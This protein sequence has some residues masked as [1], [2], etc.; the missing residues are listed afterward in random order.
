MQIYKL[1]CRN[2]STSRWCHP[3]DLALR[4]LIS[5]FF[6]SFCLPPSN[7]KM[8]C[9]NYDLVPRMRRPYWNLSTKGWAGWRL[10]TSAM[11]LRC[12]SVWMLVN[13]KW[14]PDLHVARDAGL[15]ESTK[16]LWWKH[17]G[18]LNSCNNFLTSPVSSVS[19]FVANPFTRFC[20]FSYSMSLEEL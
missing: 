18:H 2:R 9:R 10:G 14:L 17:L 7:M 19:V 11:P 12:E 13:M 16:P 4:L 15:P 20:T 3:Q 6:G 1:L 5:F 8:G